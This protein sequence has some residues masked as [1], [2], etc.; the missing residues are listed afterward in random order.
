[1]TMEAA[2]HPYED[3]QACLRVAQLEASLACNQ[4]LDSRRWF[5]CFLESLESYGAQVF[6][7]TS[8]TIPYVP[9]ES[10][11]E[12]IFSGWIPPPQGKN[13]K[14]KRV[15]NDILQ[16]L[17]QPDLA[18]LH[19]RVASSHMLIDFDTDEADRPVAIAL[20]MSCS[21]VPD[22]MRTRALLELDHLGIRPADQ[23]AALHRGRVEQ[24]LEVL[25][26]IDHL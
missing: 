2:S 22:T 4:H 3:L 23:Y 10:L 21:T 16:G 9:T 18:M 14:F 13:L 8:K 17:K 19:I 24:R 12:D 5:Q 25:C 7:R 11:F 15:G 1:M 20:H 6:E 26:N